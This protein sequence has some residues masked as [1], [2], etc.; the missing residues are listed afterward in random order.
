PRS[1]PEPAGLYRS[2]AAADRAGSTQAARSCGA[3]L[4][5]LPSNQP[6]TVPGLKR[7]MQARC[8]HGRPTGC[9]TIL[10][11]IMPLQALRW[12]AVLLLV[13]L[14]AVAF[15]TAVLWLVAVVTVLAAV[16][17]LSSKLM[18]GWHTRFTLT[19][20]RLDSSSK[21]ESD[22]DLVLDMTECP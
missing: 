14:L 20:M 22:S 15:I 17:W 1:R 6:P 5:R 4:V 16:A 19:R 18:P 9:S 7:G 2:S 11:A 10:P 12:L 3:L 8:R 13:V 21:H